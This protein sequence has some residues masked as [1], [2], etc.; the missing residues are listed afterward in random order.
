MRTFAQ[1]HLQSVEPI[2]Q[3]RPN[4]TPSLDSRPTVYLYRISGNQGAQTTDAQAGAYDL[5]LAKNLKNQ[6]P[7]ASLQASS[8]ITV[9]S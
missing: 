8:E 5:F 6:S 1:K 9:T 7:H 4:M 2:S 3:Q